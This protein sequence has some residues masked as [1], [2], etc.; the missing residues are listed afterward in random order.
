MISCFGRL[1]VFAHAESIFGK[2]KKFIYE[3]VQQIVSTIVEKG[4]RGVKI[5]KKESSKKAQK[6]R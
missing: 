3:L 5:G 2:I 4:E 6:I 1:K